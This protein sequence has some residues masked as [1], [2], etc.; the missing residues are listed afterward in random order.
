MEKLT[1]EKREKIEREKVIL[2]A[3]CGPKMFW[4]DK[5]QPNTIFIDCRKMEKGYN[6]YRKNREIS[7]DIIMDFRD[8]KFPDKKFKLIVMD[9]PH[10]VSASKNFRMARDYGILNKDTWKED[11]KKGFDECWRCLD[12]YGVLVFKWNETSIKRKDILQVLGRDPLFGNLMM[13]KIPTHWF[14]FM[15][16]PELNTNL[17]ATEELVSIPPNPKGIGYP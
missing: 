15:K 11:I 16:F 4:K 12:D 8:L 2:D 13:S 7:P 9:P 6:D 1:T 14:V 17:R 5:H 3:C 10:I